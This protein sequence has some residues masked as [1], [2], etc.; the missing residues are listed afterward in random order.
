MRTCED[1]SYGLV[2]DKVEE[3]DESMAELA[4]G[5]SNLY[6]SATRT[7]GWGICP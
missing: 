5:A 3:E 6:I 4:N 2:E 7:I 1:L